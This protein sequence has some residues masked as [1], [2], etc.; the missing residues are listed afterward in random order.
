MVK[1][2]VIGLCS[3]LVVMASC[4]S[5]EP[6]VLKH[7][8]E[9]QKVEVWV[10]GSLF[11]AY[12]Y[13]DTL[14]KP[15]LYPIYSPG[16]NII[17][18]GYPINPRPDERVDHPHHIGHW[19]NYGDVNG[20]DFWNHSYAVP[21]ENEHRYGSIVHREI[22]DMKE[23]L[24]Q[25][26][27][28]VLGHWMDHEQNILL[29]ETTTFTFSVNKNS[30]AITRETVLTAM[31][32]EVVFEDN[33][34]GMFAVRMDRAFEFPTEKPITLTGKDG[35]PRPKPII[36]NEGVNGSYQSSKG[37]EDLE[38]WGTRAKWVTLSS[39]KNGEPISVTIM[40]H[41]D[42]PGH[43]TYWHARTY[44]L[45]SAN[46][47][48]QEVFSDGKNNLTY[49]LNHKESGTFRFQIF[50]TTGK[51]ENVNKHYRVFTK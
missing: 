17:T 38:V 18:R 30:R 49:T 14:K 33:K 3:L 27:L 26:K 15:V 45:F 10:D 11:T 8:I 44:G 29:E 6:V 37:K 5:G 51:P 46:P 25:A 21:P 2:A 1:K 36:N 31:T 35:K 32:E 9:K 7:V 23:G 34:E 20:L 12:I 19:F 28:K 39:V 47:L 24:D 42:N 16:G 43:P 13:H 40:D 22:T 50:I 4:H 48:G 41:P